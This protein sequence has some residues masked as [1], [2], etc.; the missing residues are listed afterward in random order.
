[1]ANSTNGSSTLSPITLWRAK[2][3]ITPTQVLKSLS[4]SRRGPV[5]STYSNSFLMSR[6]SASLTYKFG[7]EAELY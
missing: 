3:W 2:E 6:L 5:I 4:M 1:M 7:I